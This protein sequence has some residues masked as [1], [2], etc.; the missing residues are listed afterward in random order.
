MRV[1]L[2]TDY[3]LRA[4]IYLATKRNGLTT[5]QEIAESF[6]ISRGHLMKVVH[7]LGQLGYIAT[8]R[9]KHGGIALG[10]EPSEINIGKVVRDTAE[11]LAVLGCLN[12]PAYC[13]IAKACRLRGV[14]RE[15]TAAFL[16]VLDKYT[17]EELIKPHAT[18]AN[19]LGI[20]G[21]SK[22]P[23][24]ELRRVGT[25]KKRLS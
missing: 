13:V 16:G 8:T 24:G 11:D 20:P 23:V 7:H 1:T 15:S 21:S 14:F 25:K 18:L 22:S 3:S 10:K 12:D 5:I 19:L 4:L 9:V 17:L 2:N 6:N